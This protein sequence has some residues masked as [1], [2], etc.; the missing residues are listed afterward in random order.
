MTMRCDD[1]NRW[2][3]EGASDADV[4]RSAAA[5]AHAADCPGCAAALGAFET[6]ER[7]LAAPAPS[8]PGA[9]TFTARIMEQVRTAG[10]EP[11]PASLGASTLAPWW[12]SLVAEPAF[13]LAA[14]AAF[15]FLMLPV[16]ARLE[17]GQS[18][19][20]PATIAAESLGAQLH[21]AMSVWLGAHP[22]GASLSPFA[23]TYLLV[24]AMSVSV[25][26]SFWIFGVVERMV[27]GGT[28]RR[29]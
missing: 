12:M 25:W 21:H 27:R 6:M 13:A 2:L 11:A 20:L 9:A 23:E 24:G 17:V 3:D 5:R 22:F 18:V 29:R 4:G 15:V 10:V 8:P 14:V 7:A 26:A 19:A 28:L 16:A 1:L